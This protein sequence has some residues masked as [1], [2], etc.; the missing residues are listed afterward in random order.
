MWR[1]N[2]HGNDG[3]VFEKR[4]IGRRDWD[5]LSAHIGNY[6]CQVCGCRWRGDDN[7]G[8]SG[9]RFELKFECDSFIFF[10]K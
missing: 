10:H 2:I 4:I 8:V 9:E 6:I 5:K 3:M 7:V 1:F